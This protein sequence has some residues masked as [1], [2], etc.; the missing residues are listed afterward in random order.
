[1]RKYVE[2]GKV[3][4]TLPWKQQQQQQQQ[5]REKAITCTV[6]PVR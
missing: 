2:P 3:E 6:S 1:M 4:M 5:D